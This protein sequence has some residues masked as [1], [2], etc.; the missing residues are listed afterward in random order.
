MYK[1]LLYDNDKWL[2]ELLNNE[3]K[4]YYSKF[5]FCIELRT[6]SWLLMKVYLSKYY[7]N[8]IMIKNIR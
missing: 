3:V 5:A 2:I 4:W 7:N 1:D 8:A 6:Y